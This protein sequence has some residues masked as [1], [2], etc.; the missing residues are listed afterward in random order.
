MKINST[1]VNTFPFTI[2]PLSEEDGGGFMI[3]YPDLPGCVS[4]G[5][6][7]R[8]AI[9][10]GRDAFRAS[11]FSSARHDRRGTRNAPSIIM[12]GPSAGNAE[13]DFVF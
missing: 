12:K 8:Q 13:S 1:I 9:A 4:D 7:P 11:L 5:D 3:E 6:S 2:R 10:H